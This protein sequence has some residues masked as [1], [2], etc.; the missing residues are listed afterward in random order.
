[1]RLGDI[2]AG[3]DASGNPILTIDGVSQIDPASVCMPQGWYG[4]L[5]PGQVMC[6]APANTPEGGSNVPAA[7]TAAC[8]AGATC[9]IIPGIANTSIYLGIAA[10][11]T[12]F[13]FAANMG[14]RR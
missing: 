2:T 12:V 9:S 13:F 14:G 6:S 8:P 10:V 3:L 7:S 1:M 5:A 4:P 11:V